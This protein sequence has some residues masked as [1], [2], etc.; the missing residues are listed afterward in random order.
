M[1]TKVKDELVNKKLLGEKYPELFDCL[2][3]EQCQKVHGA[4]CFYGFILLDR[5]LCLDVR[6]PS[7]LIV[8]RVETLLKKSLYFHFS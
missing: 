2:L 6:D 4:V 5:T 7:T 3:T 8:K 1:I